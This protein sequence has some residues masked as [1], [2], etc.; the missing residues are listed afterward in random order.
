MFAVSYKTGTKKW[1]VIE[2]Q[3]NVS[4]TLIPYNQ[5]TI[6]FDGVIITLDKVPDADISFEV[7]VAATVFL[8]D[9]E[10]KYLP[11][12]FELPARV[13]EAQF[14]SD[15]LINDLIMVLPGLSTKLNDVTFKNLDELS[16]AQLYLSYY[17]YLYKKKGSKR[18]TVDTNNLMLDILVS[19]NVVLEDFKRIH[20]VLDV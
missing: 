9:P 19:D 4:L 5:R 20:R 8:K 13:D 12:S 10:E 17:E 7:K 2:T 1:T 14:W 16:K 6:Y 18:I 3:N 15:Q 11:L